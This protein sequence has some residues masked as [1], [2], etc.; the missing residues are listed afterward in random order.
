MTVAGRDTEGEPAGSRTGSAGGIGC[1]FESLSLTVS[2]VTCAADAATMGVSAS[3]A[4]GD[5]TVDESD[6]GAI[7]GES[8]MAASK[9]EIRNPR[10]N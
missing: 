6:L 4:V 9:A 5:W 10:T 7:A 2:A 1:S 8:A 3:G